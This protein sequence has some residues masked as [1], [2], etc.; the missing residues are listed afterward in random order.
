[1]KRSILTVFSILT[2]VFT[3]GQSVDDIISNHID[4]L[5]GKDKVSQITSIYSEGSLNVMG[6][7]ANTK[8][9]ILRGKGY[10]SESDFNGQNLVEVITD[11][12]GWS[13][14]P[15]AGASSPTSMGDD[16]FQIKYDDLL[17]PD[18]L[19]N[20]AADS[21]KVELSGQEQIGDVNAFKIKYTNKYN[22]STDY[23]I[24]PS[25]WYIIKT[26]TT[27]SIMG[28]E[29]TVNTT[30]SKYQQS[31]YGVFFPFQTDVDL[32]QYAVSVTLTKV[33][34][35]TAVDPSIFDMPK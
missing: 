19:V 10:K 17:M 34:V 29:I 5:G 26:T 21:G 31:D 8:T 33:N 23:Y 2:F 9:T 35:N 18:P 1:M 6:M 27:A 12:G 28:Q 30:F 7:S 14:N 15:F 20:Y 13:I 22:K 24:D 16:E 25:T 11:H 32:S 3:F 4:A